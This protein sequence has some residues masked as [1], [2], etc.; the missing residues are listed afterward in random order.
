MANGRTRRVTTEELAGEIAGGVAE[1]L[2]GKRGG[3][4]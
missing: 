3:A 1:V 4:S 2:A